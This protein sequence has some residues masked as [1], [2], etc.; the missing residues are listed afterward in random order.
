MIVSR[1]DNTKHQQTWL[2]AAC[3]I[4]LA[5]SLLVAL[6]LPSAANAAFC[7]LRDPVETIGALFPEATSHKSIIKVVGEAER[8][9]VSARMPPN[10]LHFSELGQHT[11]Y[12]AFQ[13]GRPLGYV[14]VRS[15]ESDWGLVEVAWALDT[16]LNIRDFKFQRCRSSQRKAIE[17]EGFRS[18]LRGLNFTTLRPLLNDSGMDINPNRIDVPVGAESLAA[19]VVR[20]GLKTML[21]TELAWAED[22]AKYSSMAR[23]Y[24]AFGDDVADVSPINNSHLAEASATLASAF[25]GGGTIMAETQA[26]MFSVSSSDGATLGAV[27]RNQ[28]LLGGSATTLEWSIANDGQVLAITNLS[29]WSDDALQHKFNQQL[30]LHF[31]VDSQC[32]DRPGLMT[33]QAALTVAALQQQ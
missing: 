26:Q 27:Y 33:K 13:Q 32:A 12:V 4:A 17:A 9:A 2:P 3:N 25:P 20:C 23:A 7:S 6:F 15:E 31:D 29:G 16:D 5:A 21:A 19:V 18:Q 8:A 1:Y 14:H 30:G 22:V 10:T 24:S 11:L 28:L